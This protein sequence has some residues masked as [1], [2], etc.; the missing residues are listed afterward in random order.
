MV[1]LNGWC[2]DADI[3]V[4]LGQG[5]IIGRLSGIA[6]CCFTSYSDLVGQRIEF[7]DAGVGLQ[8]RASR[9]AATCEEGDVFRIELT[10]YAPA[11]NVIDDIRNRATDM[12][13]LADE[14]DQASIW[15][16]QCARIENAFDD[17]P[18]SCNGIGDVLIVAS[19]DQIDGHRLT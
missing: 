17:A 13:Y 12:L 14:R 5:E 16:G 10:D 11:G 2:I 8:H 4:V 7:A 15:I 6:S 3:L 9:N 19:A 18:L 1:N